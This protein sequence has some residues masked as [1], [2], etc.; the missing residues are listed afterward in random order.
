MELKRKIVE[1]EGIGQVEIR[2][3]DYREAEPLFDLPPEKLGKEIIKAS[4][5]YPGGERIFDSAIGVGTATALFGLVDDVLDVN[6]MGK[7]K[8]R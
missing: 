5:F 4:L 2:E 8:R 7:P 3:L 6:G 1:V